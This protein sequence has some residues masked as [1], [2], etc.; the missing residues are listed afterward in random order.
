A[1]LWPDPETDQGRHRLRY[2]V[3]P[4]AGILDAV[5]EGYA[6][7]LPLRTVAGDVPVAPLITVDS[8]DVVV[9]AVKLAEDRSGDV[10]VR[11]YA[12]SGGRARTTVRT[13]FAARSV[14]SVDLLER[15]LDIGQTWADA[16]TANVRFGPFQI[17]SLRYA[18]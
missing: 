10:V 12:A 7:N 6:I 16:T 15:P 4:G 18:R 17:V 5:R 8:P 2:G 9:E 3:V 13:G 11:L 1:P 14:H